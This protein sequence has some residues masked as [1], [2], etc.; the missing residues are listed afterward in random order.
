MFKYFLLLFIAALIS[1]PARSQ[2]DEVEKLKYRAELGTMIGLGYYQGDVNPNKLF[3][4]S[5]PAF[6]AFYQYNFS[7]RLSMRA[8]VM[9]T[10]LSGNDLDFNNA[11]QQTRAYQF[12]VGL[13]EFSGM[14]SINF[15]S[16][17]PRND[18]SLWT[19]YLLGGV[20][21]YVADNPQRKSFK[22]AYPVGFGLKFSPTDRI[23]IGVEWI[24]RIT[25]DNNIDLLQNQT[26]SSELGGQYQGRQRSFNYET[27]YYSVACVTLSCRVFEYRKRCSAYG[28]R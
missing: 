26:F 5:N 9:Q 18:N 4:S 24:Y 3:Y 28:R 1:Q 19:P 17:N 20:A 14:L 21:G 2:D 25:N 13:T 6:G 7:S 15:F 22:L 8:S 27:D 23:T 11:F 10:T 16:L 12:S